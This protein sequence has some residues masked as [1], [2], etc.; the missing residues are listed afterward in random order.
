MHRAALAAASAAAADEAVDAE[1]GVAYIEDAAGLTRLPRARG[2]LPRWVYSAAG[3][4]LAAPAFLFSAFIGAAVSREAHAAVWSAAACVAAVASVAAALPPLRAVRATPLAPRPPR[5]RGCNR[6]CCASACSCCYIWTTVIL[7]A[8]VLVGF[9]VQAPLAASELARFPP[10]GRR[11]LVPLQPGGNGTSGTLCMHIVCAGQRRS[12]S[13]P[14]LV[15]EQG[16]GSASVSFAALQ[17]ETAALGFRSCAYDR[18]GVGYSD[19]PPLGR[20]SVAAAR[21]RL[22]ALLAAAGEVPPQFPSSLRFSSL[23]AANFRAFNRRS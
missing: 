6:A 9:G 10:P 13:A 20:T 11:Y 23:A 8:V 16:G 14:L 15:M 17:V 12:A 19:S 21:D 3:W 18:S 4:A 1:N 2:A 7:S 22:A 5:P